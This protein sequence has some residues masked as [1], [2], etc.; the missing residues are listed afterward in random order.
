MNDM[1]AKDRLQGLE[2]RLRERGVVDVKFFFGLGGT[3]LGNAVSEAADVFDAI[4]AKRFDKMAPL[5]DS[6]R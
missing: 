1:N 5:G 6:A 3:S 4:L 2:A